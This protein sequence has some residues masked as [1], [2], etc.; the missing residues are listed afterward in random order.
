[1]PLKP[2]TSKDYAYNY[3]QKMRNLNNRS[4]SEELVL[5]DKESFYSAAKYIQDYKKLEWEFERKTELNALDMK[6]LFV[7]ATFQC[8]RWALISNT[9]F[10]FNTATGGEKF[11]EKIGK[12]GGRFFPTIEE[13]LMDHQV[14]Y[15]AVR[16]SANYKM[17]FA[18]RNLNPIS[19]EISGANHR[20]LTLGHDP[21]VGLIVGT[22]NIAT[23][24]LTK[25][26]SLW[27]SY[28][29]VDSEIDMPITF[30]DVLD[31]TREIYNEDPT[32]LGAAFIKQVVHAFTDIATTQGLPLPIIN[33]ISPKFS[34]FLIGN[35]I[36]TY[37]VSRGI[38]LTVLINKFVEMFH[39]LYF[40]PASDNPRLYEVKTRKVL[41]YSNTLSSVINVSYVGLTG[42]ISRIDIGGIIVTLWRLLNDRNE[43]ARIKN[44]FIMKTLDNDL[45]K[46]E[47]EVN[48]R[49]AKLG[50]N[51]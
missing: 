21:F 5:N 46:E 34:K 24:T 33:T 9:S 8:L 37:S 2:P 27:N 16:T 6:I 50:F 31:F 29:V 23:N 7:C 1:M 20:Y 19:T 35:S 41:T 36:D 30:I 14:P 15:D 49:L 17:R 42:D 47:V 4:L 26:D 39:K 12:V 10:R 11:V 18:D 48:Q 25:N 43:I 45:S 3:N 44:E 40:N 32:I 28:I 13:I 38:L 51:F 22:M